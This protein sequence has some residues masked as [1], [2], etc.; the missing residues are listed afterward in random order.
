MRSHGPKALVGLGTESVLARQLRL[1]SARLPGARIV[2]VAGFEGSRIRRAFPNVRVVDN[3]NHETTNVAESLRIGLKATAKRA[4]V[5]VVYGDLVFSPETLNFGMDRSAIVIDPNPG[6]ESEVGCVV[7]GGFV[8]NLSFGLESTWAHI[9]LMHLREKALFLERV[10]L[11]A[12]ERFFGHEL[13]NEVIDAGGRF[14]AVCPP[15]TKLVEIDDPRDVPAAR[16]LAVD[17][18]QSRAIMS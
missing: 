6:R 9:V 7:A 3:P 2:V 4:P 17:G 18:A 12:R 14:A 16:A 5:L 10:A 8:E 11:P 1:I 15:G 13:L